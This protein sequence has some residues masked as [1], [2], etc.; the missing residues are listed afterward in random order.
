MIRMP[1]LLWWLSILIG[2]TA[3]TLEKDGTTLEPASWQHHGSELTLEFR[4]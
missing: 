2:R 3:I 1:R 4:V